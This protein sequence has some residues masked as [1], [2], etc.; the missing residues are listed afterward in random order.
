MGN[1]DDDS[2]SEDEDSKT[3]GLDYPEQEEQ[4]KV[5]GA[6]PKSDDSGTTEAI[7]TVGQHHNVMIGDDKFASHD[8]PAGE[9]IQQHTS[10]EVNDGGNQQATPSSV[11]IVTH[12]DHGMF[13]NNTP[14]N[15]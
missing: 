6:V 3:D 5:D 4:F 7:M 13:P 12:S 2:E 15:D 10:E 1:C 11:D 14:P 8:E 9:A